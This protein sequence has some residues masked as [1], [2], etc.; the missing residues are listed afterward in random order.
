MAVGSGVTLAIE[1]SS[2]PLLPEA[3]HLASH[4]VLTGGGASNIEFASISIEFE[5]KVAREQKMVLHDP[6]TS[7][8]LLIALPADK[9]DALVDS[10]RGSGAGYAAVIGEVIPQVAGRKPI[11]IRA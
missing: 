3:L 11:I 8:G 7:G 6:Q 10:V 5:G 1:M 9:A 4:G 2:V